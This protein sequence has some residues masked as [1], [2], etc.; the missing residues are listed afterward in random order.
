ME[1]SKEEAESNL[2]RIFAL[3]ELAKLE[4]IEVKETEIESRMKEVAK[5]IPKD[6]KVNL[7]KLKEMVTEDI[8]QSQLLEWLEENNTIIETKTN[9]VKDKAKP[10]KTQK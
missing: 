8:L 9:P 1:S 6:Q 7:K 2:K 5:E 3:K 10:K 4:N